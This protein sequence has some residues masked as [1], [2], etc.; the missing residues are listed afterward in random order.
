MSGA[1]SWGWGQEWRV[2]TFS[3][4]ALGRGSEGQTGAS[5]DPVRRKTQYSSLGSDGNRSDLW[6]LS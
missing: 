2:D 6:C 3:S 4:A 5:S 1:E